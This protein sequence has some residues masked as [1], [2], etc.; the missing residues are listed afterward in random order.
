MRTFIFADIHKFDRSRYQHSRKISLYRNQIR[1]HY[2]SQIQNSANKFTV[3]KLRNKEHVKVKWFTVITA[4]L[5]CLNYSDFYIG[6]YLKTPKNSDVRKICCNYP[7]IWTRWLYLRVQNDIQ[8]MQLEWQTVWILRSSLIWVYSVC[9]NLSVWKFTNI[10]VI[11]FKILHCPN[12]FH[13]WNELFLFAENMHLFLPLRNKDVISFDVTLFEQSLSQLMWKRY[14]HIGKQR[15]LR[16]ACASARLIRAA[17]DHTHNIGNRQR[18]GDLGPV[19]GCACAF[20]GS[21]NAQR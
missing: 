4:I 6:K 8:T 19:D 3:T 7:K 11:W 9:P 5:G 2:A 14:F 20:E 21:L 16:W 18:A 17:T 12:Y 1:K 13:A 15:R 10:T